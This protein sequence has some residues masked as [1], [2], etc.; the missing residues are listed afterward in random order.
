MV[1]IALEKAPNPWDTKRLIFTVPLPGQPPVYMS[2]KVHQFS[3]EYAVVIVDQAKFVQLWR[4]EPCSIHK[5][6]ANGNSQTWRNDYKFDRAALGFSFGRSNPV[7]LAEVS[8]GTGKR[9]KTTPR[10]FGFGREHHEEDFHYAAIGNG[11]TRTIW[12]LAQACEAIPVCCEMPGAREL[13]RLAA[14][15]GTP[16]HT[17]GALAQT[18]AR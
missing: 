12:L 11:V 7:P 13:H 15:P 3:D 18:L 4:N 9:T 14:V 1:A 16:F 10:F 5:R 2:R 17:V 6:E 8:H